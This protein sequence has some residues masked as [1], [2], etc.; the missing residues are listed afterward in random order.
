MKAILFFFNILMLINATTIHAQ[1]LGFI[2]SECGI[3]T[4]PTYYFENFSYGSHGFGYR[5][6]HNGILIKQ[7]GENPGGCVGEDLRFINDTTGFFIVNYIGGDI[8]VYKTVGD[9]LTIVGHGWGEYLSF[10]IVNAWTAY[11]V[12]APSSLPFFICYVSKCSDIQP[13]KLLINDDSLTSNITVNDSIMGIPLCNYL[14]QVN[15]RLKNGNDTLIYT[16]FL[17]SSDSVF[18]IKETSLSELKLAPNPSSE[19]IH[20]TTFNQEYLDRVYIYNSLGIKEKSIKANAKT[21]LM[22]YIGD[23][24]NGIYFIEVNLGKTNRKIKLIK[25]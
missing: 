16:I 15:Y 25:D 24:K 19:Y 11:L 20:L 1:S 23:L 4:N 18:S 3:N 10:F 7:E 8:T 21:D 17:Y 12:S 2:E 14:T 22:I 6:Y 13:N 9:T 5:L